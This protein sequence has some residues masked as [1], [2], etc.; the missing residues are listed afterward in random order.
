MAPWG[1]VGTLFNDVFIIKLLNQ[2]DP[3]GHLSLVIELVS[4]SLTTRILSLSSCESRGIN[5]NLN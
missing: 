2:T 5:I 1:R 4:N 3:F